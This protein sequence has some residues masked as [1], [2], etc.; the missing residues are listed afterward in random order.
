MCVSAAEQ[1]DYSET[2]HVWDDCSRERQEPQ[3]LQQ[4]RGGWV[5]DAIRRCVW[6]LPESFVHTPSQRQKPG[7]VRGW[8]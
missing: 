8:E 7:A 4:Y 6:P 5:E 2:I 3:Q 1:Q